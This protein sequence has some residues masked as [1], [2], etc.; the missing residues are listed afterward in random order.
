MVL[1]VQGQNA[2]RRMIKAELRVGG[3][4]RPPGGRRNAGSRSMTFGDIQAPFLCRP[5]CENRA[6]Q[7]T[8]K[9]RPEMTNAGLAGVCQLTVVAGARFELATFGYESN[10]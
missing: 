7:E 9:L 5:V 10:G 2:H 3:R 1:P 8:G 4:K 6:V